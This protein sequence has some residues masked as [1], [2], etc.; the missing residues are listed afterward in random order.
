MLAEVSGE[1][2][3][4][5]EA[6]RQLKELLR[7]Q[8]NTSA[9]SSIQGFEQ[10]DRKFVGAITYQPLGKEVEGLKSLEQYQSARTS[11]NHVDVLRQDGLSEKDIEYV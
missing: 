4:V 10:Q 8:L 6:E 9:C 1:A 2:E 7:K 11:Y 5:S 3:V